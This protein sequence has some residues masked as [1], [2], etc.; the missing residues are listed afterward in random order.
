[1][2][3]PVAVTTPLLREQDEGSRICDESG[4]EGSLG[5]TGCTEMSSRVETLVVV[6]VVV[7][8]NEDGVELLDTVGSEEAFEA[9]VV[10]VWWWVPSR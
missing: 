1:L 9:T 8:A 10:G 6:V 5:S 7:D 2:K 3:V 4:A